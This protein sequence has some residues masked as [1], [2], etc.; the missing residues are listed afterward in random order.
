MSQIALAM[1]N[2]ADSN[3]DRLPPAAVCGEDGTPLL[4]WRVL[5]LPYIEQN[6]L[7]KQ[8]HLDE[9]WDS[10]HN[11]ELLPKMPRTYAAPGSK[12]KKLPP[13]HTVCHVFFGKGAAFEGKE[14]L[15]LPGDFIDGTSNTILIV[16]AGE[17]VPWT[18]PDEILFDPDKPVPEL[19][20][21][22]RDGFRVG[23]ADGSRRWI[24]MDIDEKKL[25]EAI[26]RD[27]GVG[28]SEW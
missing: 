23:M 1:H 16:E 15:R 26:R 20:R 4:S 11:I 5:L 14:G 22:F 19:R 9:P 6:D 17:P 21:I 2:Y 28:G 3:D 12:A 10:P 8:F 18:K 27:D 13:Y 24:P 7:Y 25:R